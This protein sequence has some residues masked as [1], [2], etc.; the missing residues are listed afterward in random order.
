MSF[1]SADSGSQNDGK[2][3]RLK[4]A[5]VIDVTGGSKAVVAGPLVDAQQKRDE[6]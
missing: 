5:K 1:S 4:R 3:T 2:K 6:L